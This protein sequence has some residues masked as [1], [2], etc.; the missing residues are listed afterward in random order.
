MPEPLVEQV[1]QLINSALRRIRSG[2]VHSH[3]RRALAGAGADPSRCSLTRTIDSD[4]HSQPSLGGRLIAR[5]E[6]EYLGGGGAA[7]R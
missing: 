7:L 3:V 4:R 6:T 2:A 5:A 1:I